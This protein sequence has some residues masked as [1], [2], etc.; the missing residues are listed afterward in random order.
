MRNSGYYIF[1]FIMLLPLLFLRDVTPDNELK[2]LS[3]AGEAIENGNFF[4]FTNLG[5]PYAD[6][7]PLYLWI[8]MA[9]KQVL[10]SY[11]V[12]ILLLFSLIPAF[13]TIYIMDRWVNNSLTKKERSSGKWML[14][15]TGLFLGSALVLRMDM[16]MTMFIALSLYLFYL[17]WSGEGTKL[18]HWMF[19]VMVFM[20]IFSKG[21]VGILMP[22][23]SITVF[24]LWNRQIKDWTKYWGWHTW[25][26]ILVLCGLWFTGVYFDGGEEYLNNLLFNQTVNRA[27]D[28]F[29]H[30][31]PLWYYTK[32][33]WYALAPWSIL[34]IGVIIIAAFKGFIKTPLEKFFITVS[35]ST[36]VMLSMISAKIDIY[37][38]PAYP[39]ICYAALL[40]IPKLEKSR[41]VK[42]FIA[43]P[44]VI[45]ILILPTLTMDILPKD[46]EF[47]SSPYPY[48]FAGIICVGGLLSLIFN[49]KGRIYASINSISISLIVGL[50]VS[51]T[52]ITILNPDI[53]LREV[54]LRANNITNEHNINQIYTY[55][56]KCGDNAGVYIN[57][58]ITAL[59]TG[60]LD[61]LKNGVVIFRNSDIARDSVLNNR[62]SRFGYYKVGNN[63]IMIINNIKSLF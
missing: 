37:M 23:V 1:V 19:P 29:H 11:S 54:V 32:T 35:A 56:I 51:S 42:A 15:T 46:I 8:V 6:K 25:S 18:T 45:F 22:L 12:G 2:Y 55:R 33:I 60:Q 10:G 27:I 44:S 9:V 52:G 41:W 20:A 59:Q 28:S 38:L 58:D 17:N 53:G 50:F 47:L 62:I 43:I 14:I 24:L 63:S 3:I 5:V 26:V 7:P 48:I 31:A 13:V 39:F 34:F 61:S 49:I 16:L 57:K 36:F 30:K 21:A 4:A 40:M